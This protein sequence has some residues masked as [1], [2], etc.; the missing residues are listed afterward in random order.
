MLRPENKKTRQGHVWMCEYRSRRSVASHFLGL[1]DEDNVINYSTFQA[2][3]KRQKSDEPLP[4]NP[5]NEQ[6]L[7][8]CED[9]G[10]DIKDDDNGGE[11]DADT[12][13]GC[14]VDSKVGL[15]MNNAC[16]KPGLNSQS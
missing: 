1:N 2:Q 8:V 10:V 7:P 9:N 6:E 13:E 4:L 15:K 14:V 5:S 12:N 16:L 11:D 3:R